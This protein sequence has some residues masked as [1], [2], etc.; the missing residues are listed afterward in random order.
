MG[1][2]VISSPTKKPKKSKSS[3]ATKV[4]AKQAKVRTAKKKL[5]TSESNAEPEAS[6]E[7]SGGEMAQVKKVKISGNDCCELRL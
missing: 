4:A 1:N 7:H 5:S 2:A 3:Q 6:N